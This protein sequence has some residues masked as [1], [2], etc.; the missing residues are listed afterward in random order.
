MGS[1]PYVRVSGGWRHSLHPNECPD[2]GSTQF[3]P[4]FG[5]KMGPAGSRGVPGVHLRSPDLGPSEAFRAC[6]SPG[7]ALEWLWGA[8]V[9]LGRPGD[10]YFKKE[11][12]GPWTPVRVVVEGAE[13]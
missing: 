10:H 9:V 13:I 3:Y 11:L 6:L 12:F 2:D 5:P 1:E 8:S 4:G 7:I